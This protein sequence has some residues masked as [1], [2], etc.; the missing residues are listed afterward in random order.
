MENYFIIHVLAIH[1]PNGPVYYYYYYC[2]ELKKK[3]E[4]IVQHN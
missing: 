3:N 1:F 4:Y 2:T